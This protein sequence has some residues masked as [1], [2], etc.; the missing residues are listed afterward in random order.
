MHRLVA[1]VQAVF[2]EEDENH[3]SLLPRDCNI[4]SF[5]LRNRRGRGE[6]AVQSKSYPDARCSPR[7]S[8]PN[9][10]AFPEKRSVESTKEARFWAFMAPKEAS[11]SRNGR[12][13]LTATFCEMNS[14]C[15]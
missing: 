5:M 6:S 14:F 3:V 4:T 15:G 13:G 7:P 1:L 8:S 11:A 2:S 10:S 9:S 12:R